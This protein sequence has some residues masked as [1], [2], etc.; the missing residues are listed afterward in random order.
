[1]CKR[2]ASIQPVSYTHLI[3]SH[4]LGHA[5]HTA[6]A[7]RELGVSL[8]KPMTRAMCEFIKAKREALAIDVYLHIPAFESEEYNSFEAI[9]RA[10]DKEMGSRG[11][12]D[13]TE[14]IAQSVAMVYNGF[15]LYTSSVV[16]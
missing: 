9:R 13:G 11:T 5:L 7:A 2:T 16:R 15:L 4:E 12:Y 10:V 1:M 3:V 14:F 8:D 6:A